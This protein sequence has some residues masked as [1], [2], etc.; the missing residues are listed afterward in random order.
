MGGTMDWETLLITIYVYNQFYLF[1]HCQRF[2]NNCKQK[3]TDEEVITIY[4]FGIMKKQ[5]T[6]KDIYCYA[7]I[8]GKGSLRTKDFGSLE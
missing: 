5:F 4:L 3:F 7:A 6:I 2:S 8:P 1:L